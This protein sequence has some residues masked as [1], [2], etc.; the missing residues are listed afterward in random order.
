[1]I[2]KLKFVDQF[3]RECP[4]KTVNGETV[5]STSFLRTIMPLPQLA[6]LI[7]LFSAKVKLAVTYEEALQFLHTANYNV[8][9]VYDFLIERREA[10][11]T[12]RLYRYGKLAIIASVLA[13]FYSLFTV[14]FIL[15]FV[16]MGVGSGIYR[17]LYSSGQA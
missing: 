16:S 4:A 7:A 1:M 14:N 12:F 5:T 13:V 10:R 8:A 2:T 11:H 6:R 3:I 17:Y 9:D 15:C